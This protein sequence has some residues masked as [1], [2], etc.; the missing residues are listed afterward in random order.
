MTLRPLLRMLCTRSR[1]GCVQDNTLPKLPHPYAIC[2]YI[3]APITKTDYFPSY[4]QNVNWLKKKSWEFFYD[5]GYAIYCPK[6]VWFKDPGD[7][8]QKEYKSILDMDLALLPRYDVIYLRWGWQH[9][10]GC[11]IEHQ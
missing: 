5:K 8:N 10:N 11:R 9:S 3:S 4:Q 2:I 6:V 7:I 1:V